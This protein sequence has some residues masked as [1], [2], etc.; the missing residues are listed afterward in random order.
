[1]G[2]TYREGYSQTH[3]RW[4]RVKYPRPQSMCK[5]RAHLKTVI[6]RHPLGTALRDVIPA[7]NRTLRGWAAYFKIGNSYR[8]GEKLGHYV[9][10]QLR[11]FWRRR[12]QCKRIPG[13]RRWPDGFFYDQGLHYV[14]QLL[15]A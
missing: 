13:V 1:M 5:I 10:A 15:R 11:L 6:R 9:C 7:V 8:A 4:V 14:P 12:R 3:Q 2:F